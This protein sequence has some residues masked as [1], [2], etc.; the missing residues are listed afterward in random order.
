[1]HEQT[2]VLHEHYTA[3]MSRKTATTDNGQQRPP[4]QFGHCSFPCVRSEIIRYRSDYIL[5]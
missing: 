3:F 4:P 2:L 1:M 5:R